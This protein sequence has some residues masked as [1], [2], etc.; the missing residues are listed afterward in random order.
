MA[1]SYYHDFGGESR[2]NDAAQNDRMN[3]GRWQIGIASFVT[4][5]MQLQLQAGKASKTENGA[6]E[7]NRANF[8]LVSVL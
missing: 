3:N 2:L 6:R 1:L 5:T 4:S 8:R 7:S